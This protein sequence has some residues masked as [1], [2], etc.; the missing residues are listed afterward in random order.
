MSSIGLVSQGLMETANDE[1]VRDEDRH[2]DPHVL[3]GSERSRAL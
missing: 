1:R 2:C 3:L